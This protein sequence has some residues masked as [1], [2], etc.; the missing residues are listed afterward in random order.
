MLLV[1]CVGLESIEP[2]KV[3]ISKEIVNTGLKFLPDR[4][5]TE[6]DTKLDLPVTMSG[7]DGSAFTQCHKVSLVTTLS[8][9]KIF[10][11]HSTSEEEV[12]KIAADAVGACCGLR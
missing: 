1:S 8:D 2:T 12:I 10:D 9:R 5:E 11:E 4:L 7:I 6:V 3:P